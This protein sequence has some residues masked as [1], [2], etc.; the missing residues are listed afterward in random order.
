[1]SKHAIGST[2]LLL[3]LR[4]K[5]AARRMITANTRQKT[6]QARYEALYWERYGAP[7]L[8]QTLDQGNYFGCLACGKEATKWLGEDWCHECDHNRHLT[9]LNEQGERA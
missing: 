8:K 3:T 5:M 9:W 4:L 6:A 2:S 1:M 7:T